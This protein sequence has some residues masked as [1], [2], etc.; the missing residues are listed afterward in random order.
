MWRPGEPCEE[1]GSARRPLTSRKGN[2]SARG[3]CASVEKSGWGSAVDEKGSA[4]ARAEQ[5]RQ[6]LE[7]VKAS[8]KGGKKVV[9]KHDVSSN[10]IQKNERQ[11][12]ADDKQELRDSKET[13][14]A[15]GESER[16]EQSQ[17]TGDKHQAVVLPSTPDEKTKETVQQK[18]DENKEEKNVVGT[19][20]DEDRREE[21]HEKIK[22]PSL[23]HSLIQWKEWIMVTAHYAK[24]GYG[25]RLRLGTEYVSVN[26]EFE[27]LEIIDPVY[28][29]P[30]HP[31]TLLQLES[32]ED[33]LC[34]YMLRIILMRGMHIAVSDDLHTC[35]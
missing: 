12:V 21:V 27:R 23:A 34:S 28:P 17:Q 11:K 5:R 2:G 29:I 25:I 26:E 20:T 33:G 19:G 3:S 30:E 14:A 9:G 35:L 7:K 1:N 31:L 16:K 15:L 10:V 4:K 24:A 8:V 6:L 22:L 32:D 13:T 18:V